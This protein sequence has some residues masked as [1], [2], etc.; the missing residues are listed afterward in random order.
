VLVE[1]KQT[2]CVDA[3]LINKYLAGRNEVHMFLRDVKE[4]AKKTGC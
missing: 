3:E 1:S 2:L 4:E